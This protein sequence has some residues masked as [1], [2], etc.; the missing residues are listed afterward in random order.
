MDALNDEPDLEQVRSLLRAQYGELNPKGPGW[1]GRLA[2]R[3][4]PEPKPAEWVEHAVPEVGEPDDPAAPAAANPDVQDEPERSAANAP[5]PPI[6][7]EPLSAIV[8]RLS[9]LASELGE[10]A[11]EATLTV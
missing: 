7:A 9:A 10:L 6:S 1:V 11:G 4:R 3:F 8:G 2:E 5:D